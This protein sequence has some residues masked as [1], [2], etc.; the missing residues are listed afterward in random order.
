MHPFQISLSSGLRR[1][2]SSLA[3]AVLSDLS[4]IF[5][6]CHAFLL[7]SLFLLSLFFGLRRHPSSMSHSFMQPLWPSCL[8]L[9]GLIYSSFLQPSIQMGFACYSFALLFLCLLSGLWLFTGFAINPSSFFFL[10]WLSAIIWAS[11]SIV[12]L[13]FYVLHLSLAYAV[14]SIVWLRLP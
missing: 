2:V 13:S 5:L 11:P 14:S 4:I 7:G 12:A 9:L 3:I 1:F 8:M 6:I 10:I